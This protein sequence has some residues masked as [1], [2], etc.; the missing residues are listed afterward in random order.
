MA[1][2]EQYGFDENFVEKIGDEYKCAMCLLVL[3]SPIQMACGHRM[4]SP[5]FARTQQH[6][7]QNNIP[8]TCPLDRLPVSPD[9]VFP[10]RG[11]TRT[12]GNLKVKCR[13][14]ER[15]CGWIGDL[16]DLAT[17]RHRCR[18]QHVAVGGAGAAEESSIMRELLARVLSCEE[19][20][21]S[22]EKDAARQDLVLSQLR[23][24]L[25]SQR[26]ELETVKLHNQQLVE[27]VSQL[28]DDSKIK[29]ENIIALQRSNKQLVADMKILKDINST[30][31]DIKEAIRSSYVQHVLSVNKSHE[32]ELDHLQSQSEDTNFASKGM[33]EEK[34]EVNTNET[35]T[36]D[37][38]FLFDQPLQKKD[39]VIRWVM[40]DYEKSRQVGEPVSSL[41][42]PC[43]IVDGYRF[44]FK[45]MWLGAEL[46]VFLVLCTPSGGGPLPQL[47][48]EY[49]I[50]VHKKDGLSRRAKATLQLIKERQSAIEDEKRGYSFF[51]K[52][53]DEHVIDD[54]LYVSCTFHAE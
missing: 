14:V 7:V 43:T 4:C 37:D 13:N 2:D 24:E 54:S 40:R 20:L 50:R 51:T 5:C 49:T 25:Q 47:S 9:D 53:P 17:H 31:S 19:K 30:K 41:L 26:S 6:A 1:S 45:V 27:E 35:E 3:R 8:L 16:R 10:D 22:K 11:M 44:K 12:V 38:F 18:Y 42:F 15:G 32:H 46:W 36:L 33:M 48:H 23:T 28:K 34:V 21:A 52:N 29:Q 39:L